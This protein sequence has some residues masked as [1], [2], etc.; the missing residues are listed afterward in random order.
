MKNRK[1]LFV[2]A[3]ALLLVLLATSASAYDMPEYTSTGCPSADD[4]IHHWI[5]DSFN[6]PWC[7]TSGSGVYAC[8]Y[9]GQQQT[10]TIPALGHDWGP[11]VEASPATCVQQG[12]RHRTCQRCQQM[13]RETFTGDHKW[14]P[15][16][17]NEP[18]DCVHR[19]LQLRKCEYCGKQEWRYWG[20]L[21]DH[22]WGE[23][24]IVK[25]PT[26][27]E[28]GLRRRI[29]KIE[30]SHV[31][32]EELPPT[33]LIPPVTLEPEGP[34]SE[35]PSSDPPSITRQYAG[36]SLSVNLV[37]QPDE[38][39]EL[40]GEYLFQVTVSNDSSF[41]FTGA[42]VNWTYDGH[43]DT[44]PSAGVG[45]PVVPAGGGFTFLCKYT[46]KSPG[47]HLLSWQAF[48]ENLTYDAPPDAEVASGTYSG[49]T[50]WSNTV[51][52]TVG[53][54]VIPPPPV[55]EPVTVTKAEISA[56]KVG[57]TYQEGEI[58]E[59]Q[60]TVTNNTDTDMT[61]ALLYDVLSDTPIGVL[62]TLPAHDSI[63]GPYAYKVTADDVAAGQVVNYAW[64]E[65][66]QVGSLV[67][68]TVISNEVTSLTGKKQASA[69][70]SLSATVSPDKTVYTVGETV[71]FHVTVTNESTFD[72]DGNATAAWMSH[73]ASAS[74]TYA[75]DVGFPTV[76][77]GGSFSFDYDYKLEMAGV[78]NISW[79]GIA[80][81]VK[82]LE[83]P[84]TQI[85]S[86]TADGDVLESNSVDFRLTAEMGGGVTI[87]KSVYSDPDNGTYYVLGE[88]IVYQLEVFNGTAYD[89]PVE[90]T[91]ILYV[92]D[93]IEGYVES[94]ATLFVYVDY[95]VTE[96][97][98]KAGQVVNSAWVIWEDPEN[99]GEEG[100]DQTEEVTV[101]TGER[102]EPVLPTLVK[103]A[104]DPAN[105]VFFV[106]GEDV[107]FTVT[108][109]N[110]T[111]ETISSI[112][113]YDALFDY[114]PLFH[115]DSLAPGASHSESFTYTVTYGDCWTGWVTNVAYAIVGATPIHQGFTVTSN[116]VT[117]PCGFEER[118]PGLSIVKTEISSRGEKG[119]YA[120]GE[121]ILYSIT[122]V[123][124]YDVP[125]YDAFLGDTNAPGDGIIE[126]VGT[127]LP[128]ESYGTYFEYTV[129]ADDVD[130][131]E[132]INYA[133]LR[134][135]IFNTRIPTTF[136]SNEV[137]S[138][139]GRKVPTPPNPPVLRPHKG[140]ESCV[141]TLINDG[142][143]GE[144]YTVHYCPVHHPIYEQ[145]NAAITKA[146]TG[147][148]RLAVWQQ[149]QDTWLAAL[150]QQ[151]DQLAQGQSSAVRGVIAAEKAAFLSYVSSLEAM[152]RDGAEEEAA[153][154][155]LS[156][157]LMNQ[158]VDL[159]YLTAHAG[160][161]RPDSQLTGTYGP[162]DLPAAMGECQRSAAVNPAGDIQYVELMEEKHATLKAAVNTML[163]D[164]IASLDKMDLFRK[165]QSLWW[166][167]L[168][169]TLSGASASAG[170]EQKAAIRE[171]TVALNRLLNARVAMMEYAYPGYL[172][173]AAEQGYLLARNHAL[174]LCG[175][176]HPVTASP[177]ATAVPVPATPEPTA[178]PTPAPTDAPNGTLRVRV[179]S[180]DGAVYS[181]DSTLNNETMT[182]NAPFTVKSGTSG[183]MR[184]KPGVYNFRAV[185]QGG[186]VVLA[187]NGEPVTPD[188]DGAYT[189]TITIVSEE[190][191]EIQ[192][193]VG[194]PAVPATPEPTAV[195]T[196]QRTNVP[197][198][199]SNV[200]LR[201]EDGGV[202][203]VVLTLLDAD[204]NP[205]F[206]ANTRQTGGSSFYSMKAGDY[207]L[208]IEPSEGMAVL[209][210]N[211]EPAVSEAD[212]SCR[213]PVSLGLE[214][215]KDF[216]VLI[217]QKPAG[218]GAAAD[219]DASSFVGEWY[220]TG[221]N[222][223]GTVI[224]PSALGMSM[225]MTLEDDGSLFAEA[226]YG[227]EPDVTTGT[228]T[229]ENGVVT[230]VME[231]EPGEMRYENDE[232]HYQLSETM[233]FIFSRE[234]PEPEDQPVHVYADSEDDFLG[235]W[236]FEWVGTNGGLISAS[237]LGGSGS[238][239]I[240][241]GELTMT[242]DGTSATYPT[243]FEDGVLQFTTENEGLMLIELND[244]GWLSI[245]TEEEGDIVMSMY[246]VPV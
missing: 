239:S 129:T 62:S 187:V 68:Q 148:E 46:M 105:G 88:H 98:V 156:E 79:A 84:S 233:T 61:G 38:G 140:I 81:S 102:P 204:G 178:A 54:E 206:K 186:A 80:Y 77:A 194:A 72:L 7:T 56:P 111:K 157:L 158:T 180:S 152:L 120:E 228:W 43:T 226:Y 128:S 121:K 155:T 32:E 16:K 232:L 78:Y 28:P 14:G 242:T 202:Y 65:W 235:D 212:G 222:M 15:W 23:W 198:S 85:V 165:A 213:V 231:G 39:E 224:A 21:G 66:T 42:G 191:Q 119:Y 200:I 219:S 240:R 94:K 141:R 19:E 133:W 18:A 8:I 2:L 76:P 216:K 142:D 113:V 143:T 87:S 91:D 237:A 225:S 185:P 230:A 150:E 195:P 170:E 182:F 172:S 138:P 73:G 116:E 108:I 20:E 53:G 1:W 192:I 4:G 67:P 214:E 207:I 217:G 175:L 177:A 174:T 132:V 117:V 90:V 106:E 37:S 52:Y 75:S 210:V 33:G 100:W 86:G 151:Y 126:E 146:T 199:V 93:P 57:T 229:Y 153:A 10:R 215:R 205:K 190:T 123:N 139:T 31:E 243:T 92:D 40:N 70:L 201:A 9:C 95:T 221:A 45:M 162:L 29:C 167:N 137:K 107:T 197:N 34:T 41:D 44:I 238:L 134:G 173:L 103:E 63:S 188:A 11:W 114:L 169:R 89:L 145:I 122:V 55:T 99:P 160:E 136:L 171:H 183:T 135:T 244:N 124:N 71:T 58:I 149:A 96:D 166:T 3:A 6:D 49:G 161:P 184:R 154:K 130:A 12:M 163:T 30:A 234:Q 189:A 227:D 179:I 25:E 35:P 82:E 36:I 196:P 118:E 47:S 159:C 208:V 236:S 220:L 209:T 125:I 176:W 26:D 164:P 127:L 24:E 104:S 83:D 144:E 27:T 48:E 51:E 241:P 218:G 245:T 181:L 22:K 223:G 211:D 74:A 97:D 69:G 246:F 17:R 13:E 147:A 5:W 50:L 59:Y 193:T 109:V 203:D 64:V 168:S 131:G 110:D 115:L 60:I 112:Y 101:P